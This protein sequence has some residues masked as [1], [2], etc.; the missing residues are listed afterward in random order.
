MKLQLPSSNTLSRFF[1]TALFL[2]SALSLGFK[3]GDP[4]PDFE[5]KN[6]D[7]KTIKLSQFLGKPVIL[8]FY[9]KDQTPGCTTEA[10]NFRDKFSVFQ[11]QGA[12]LLGVSTQDEKS[13]K[14]FQRKYHLPFDLL[15]DTDG[16]IA[17]KMQV[18]SIPVLGYHKRRTLLIDRTGHLF[19]YYESVEPSEHV[20][21]LM[22]DLKVLGSTESHKK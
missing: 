20:F 9:P 18:S 2:A 6:Q 19:K 22:E 1:L 17:K 7:G 10:C 16:Q 8:F 13:H 14:L 12:V 21:Q 15:V 3:N 5:A 11:K 4:I